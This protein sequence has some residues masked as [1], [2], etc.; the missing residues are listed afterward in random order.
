MQMEEIK[1]QIEL[2]RD[3]FNTLIAKERS[4]VRSGIREVLA[5]SGV[6]PEQIDTIV[7]T[8]GSS[9]I[10]TFQAL[11]RS[12][13]PKAKIVASDLFGSVTG[14]LAMI[15]HTLIHKTHKSHKSHT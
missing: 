6:K 5:S 3:E 12:E 9:S 2:S 4:L 10:P 1:L 13:L 7:A 11:L 14:G 8:G 15:G